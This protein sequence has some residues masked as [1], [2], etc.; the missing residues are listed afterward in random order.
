MRHVVITAVTRRLEDGG[1][2]LPYGDRRAPG[3]RATI[4]VLPSDFG[5]NRAAVDRLVD[6]APEVYNHNT[7]TV[8]RL[9]A[10]VRGRKSDYRWTLEMFRRIGTRNPAIRTKTGLML[11]LG[12]THEELLDTLADLLDAGCRMPTMGSICSRR[13]I[14]CPWSGYCR[15]EFAHLGKLAPH[16]VPARGQRAVRAFQLSRGE[17][18]HATVHGAIVAS[19]RESATFA[20]RKATIRGS[21]SRL[22]TL[23]DPQ[24]LTKSGHGTSRILFADLGIDDQPVKVSLGWS[25]AARVTEGE[26]LWRCYWQLPVDLPSPVSGTLWKPCRRSYSSGLASD[27]Q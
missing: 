5:G 17:M 7:E 21:E 13:R 11:G 15:R 16:G 12:E 1:P 24:R 26:Q 9:Y 27:W 3:D 14:T 23:T 8:P 6:I 10:R 20:E 25:N 2:H 22:R 19:L 18:I 4:E